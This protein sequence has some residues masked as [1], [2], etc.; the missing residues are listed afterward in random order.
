MST[1]IT[2]IGYKTSFIKIGK[3]IIIWKH[4]RKLNYYC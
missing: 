1:L 3:H 2:N 4:I